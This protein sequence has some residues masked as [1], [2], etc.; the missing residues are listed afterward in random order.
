MTDFLTNYQPL[1]SK[2]LNFRAD[3]E[4]Q[5]SEKCFYVIPY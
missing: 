1:D 2:T 3:E 5:Q 4:Y